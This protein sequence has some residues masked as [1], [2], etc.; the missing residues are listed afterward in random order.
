[1]KNRL[2]IGLSVLFLAASCDTKDSD[3]NIYKEDT[4]LTFFT[5][6]DIDQ[7]RTITL[8]ETGSSTTVVT[9]GSTIATDA[10]R[11]YTVAVDPASTAQ[12]GVHFDFVPSSTVTIPAGEYV[13]SVT[14]DFDYFTLPEEGAQL[15]LN[16]T[17]SNLNETDVVLT[18]N[19]SKFC[20]SDLSGTHSFVTTNLTAGPGGVCDPSASGEVTWTEGDEGIYT[21]TDASFGQ[22]GA[23]Y[24][25]SGAVG[26]KFAHVCANITV[27]MTPDQYGDTYTYT[28]VSV[29]G[30]DMVIQWINTYGD[31]GTT[32]IT[33]QDGE[34]WPAELQ[35]N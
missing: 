20:A 15:I 8:T 10:D 11:T 31:G 6:N 32:T 29:D 7:E 18:I 19:A 9:V 34:P 13:G 21:T 4:E 5:D 35:I 17:G 16:L 1:M 25:D 24:G 14:I 22:F 23:C 33:R 12:E 3:A 27:D 26:P 28:I 2:L 30:A